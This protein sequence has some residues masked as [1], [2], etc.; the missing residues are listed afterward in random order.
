MRPSRSNYASPPHMVPKKGTMKCRPVGDYHALNAQTVKEKYPIPY[1]ADFKSELHGTKAE[2]KLEK[3]KGKNPTG[4]G[5]QRP[6]ILRK[7][8]LNAHLS[9][10][11]CA[12]DVISRK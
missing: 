10:P 3:K 1:I 4:D 7:V 11:L 12:T 6:C 2:I 8:A 5:S 9:L